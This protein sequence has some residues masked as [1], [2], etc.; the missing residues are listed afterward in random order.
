MTEEIYKAAIIG[1]GDIAR[2]HAKTYQKYEQTELVALAD[3]DSEA[4]KKFGGKFSIPSQS[5]YLNHMGMLEDEDL[6]IIS[7]CTW[8][9]T[10]SELSIDAAKMGIKGII[11]EKPMSTS[12]GESK[13]MIK[14]AKANNVKLTV[15]HNKRYIFASGK[16]RELI[17][18]GAIGKPVIVATHTRSGLLNWGT[19]LIDQVR[20]LLGD[21]ETEWVIG[22]VER[23]TDRY[24]RK[25][26]IEDLCMGVVCFDNGARMEFES[27][28]PGPQ[29][30]GL[31]N[32]PLVIGTEGQIK[33]DSSD[34]LTLINKDGYQEIKATDEDKGRGGLL[35]HLDE[36]LEWIEGKRDNHRCSGNQAFYTTEI[37]MSIY[38][39]L[40][41]KGLVSMPLKTRSSPLKA[42]LEEGTLSVEKPGKYDIRIPYWE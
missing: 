19:H 25:E 41:T 1:C 9:G 12:V 42:M 26:P 17:T 34:K 39:S 35:A 15:E 38:E 22:Q 29:I 3:I 36:L 14:T 5:Q 24:E 28:L 10:H 32:W 6:D 37:M 40:R 11:C 31:K 4:L 16:A 20:Y 21:P 30:S 8:H 27:D 33:L 2:A 7:V 13:E 18:V 23:K